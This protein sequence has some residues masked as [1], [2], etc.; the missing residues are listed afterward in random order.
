MADKLFQLTVKNND[1]LASLVKRLEN[2]LSELYKLESRLPSCGDSVEIQSSIDY[3]V[4]RV[5]QLGVQ[6]TELKEAYTSTLTV[7]DGPFS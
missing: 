7:R 2:E 4:S 3:H 1:Q 6:L 5:A